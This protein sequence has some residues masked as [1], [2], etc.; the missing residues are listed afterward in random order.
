MNAINKF[1]AE[2]KAMMEEHKEKFEAFPRAFLV[3]V[4]DCVFDA[5]KN[6]LNHNMTCHSQ[7]VGG[8]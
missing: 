6:K 4:D 7:L 8:N 5:R 2:S 1:T 3:L